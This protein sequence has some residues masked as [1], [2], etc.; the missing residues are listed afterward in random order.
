MGNCC[1]P[2]VACDVCDG[3]F[4]LLAVACDVYDGVFLSCPFF[5]RDVLD[6]TLNFIESV[7]EGFPS[8]SLHT[9]VVLIFLSRVISFL[10]PVMLAQS[11]TIILSF[12]MFAFA[13]TPST[14]QTLNNKRCCFPVRKNT[15]FA[16]IYVTYALTNSLIKLS[17]SQR[18][19]PIVLKTIP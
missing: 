18:S 9:L 17:A 5:Q 2:G 14:V 13:P 4:F 11:A 19:L 10:S 15:I 7:S 16:L 6:V 1:S 8:Y 12:G 3:V